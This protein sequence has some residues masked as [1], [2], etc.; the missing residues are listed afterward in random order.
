MSGK[1]ATMSGNHDV[2]ILQQ[3][4]PG[5]V[6]RECKRSGMFVRMANK[7]KGAERMKTL[8]DCL[9]NTPQSHTEKKRS[10]LRKNVLTTS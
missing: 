8:I 2:Q 1:N 10:R 5:Q 4:H 6:Q 7:R 3:P 9:L